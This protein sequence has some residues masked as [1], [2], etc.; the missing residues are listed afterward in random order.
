VRI[1]RS[2]RL[3]DLTQ[4]VGAGRYLCGPEGRRYLGET[5]FTQH[6]IEL[7]DIEPPTADDDP[8]WAHAR[9]G[10]ALWPLAQFGPLRVRAALDQYAAGLKR[11][12]KLP[13]HHEGGAK[14]DHSRA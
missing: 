10:S 12:T 4:S 5:P 6:G 8:L 3:A 7:T 11:N 13:M 14:V 1:G 9:T 2:L